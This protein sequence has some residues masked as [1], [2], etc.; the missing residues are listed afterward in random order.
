MGSIAKE[1]GITIL[2]C[3]AIVLILGVIFY[4]YIPINVV[5]PSDVEQ[6]KTSSAIKEEIDEEIVE[7][8][9]EDLIFEIT[10]S[11]LTLY[12]RTSSY[13]QGKDHPFAPYVEESVGTD[14]ES[15]SS[16]SQNVSTG[17]S[18]TVTKSTET[19]FEDTKLK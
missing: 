4:N 12:R 19:F 15:G 17:E 11:D 8:P 7:Y 9:K 10:D 2:L 18:K 6:Y 5:V 3:I 13:K 1:I 16:G 14:V